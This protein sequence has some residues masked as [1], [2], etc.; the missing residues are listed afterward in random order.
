MSNSSIE[1]EAFIGRRDSIA[2][3]RRFTLASVL[4]V[5]IFYALVLVMVL[6]AVPYGGTP[7]WW[8]GLF[9]CLVFFL[10]SLAVVERWLNKRYATEPVT[11]LGT[12]PTNLFI[13]LL[14]I[15]IYAVVQ[16]IPWRGTVAGVNV[17]WTLSWDALGT[18]MFIV[19]L[20]ALIAFGMLIV[21]YTARE[22]R[23]PFVVD[24]IVAI[25][26][27]SAV[28]GLVRQLTQQHPGFG[29]PQLK[30]GF[31]Y[32]QF[33]NSNHFAFLMEMVLGLVLGIVVKSGVSGRRRLIFLLAALVMWVAVV[34]VNSRGGIVSMLSQ[35]VL[36]GVLAVSN[37]NSM[38]GRPA[39][40][41]AKRWAL[42]AS[43]IL[44]L[45]AG[46]LITVL[47]VGGDPLA[48]R[49]ETLSVELNQ[50]TA[51][52]YTLRQNIWQA[53]WALIKDHP[54]GGVG[55]GGYWIAIPQ[56]HEASGET[57]PQQAHNDYLELMASGGII[58]VALAMWFVIALV[59]LARG[60][61]ATP[62]TS[63]RAIAL[64]AIVGIL[65]VS[66]HS[67]VD[68]GL[69]VPINAVIFTALVALVSIAAR[70]TGIPRTQVSSG[71]VASLKTRNT[72]RLKTTRFALYS[73]ANKP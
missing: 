22:R 11:S 58:A 41:P 67:F 66:I 39:I 5:T 25:G 14:A 31:G 68:F 48:G 21:R 47:F 52:T 61:V 49:I 4:N 59:R 8:Q 34:R 17:Q 33:I 42:N 64:G 32:A 73:A 53:T 46:A 24:T 71:H 40:S 69:H 6:V 35:V 60:A 57:A 62:D 3:V 10:A 12:L 50:R 28:F 44:V 51:Q 63:R 1:G 29:L 2:G 54:I 30:P 37:R 23:L 27:V 18:K 15:I 16:T 26:F 45:L 43:L 20:C 56:Y 65:T 55:F 70:Q 36:L 13:P 19:Q 9:Q 72:N 7:P 38:T